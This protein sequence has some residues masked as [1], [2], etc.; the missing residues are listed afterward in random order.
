MK[1]TQKFLIV[2][3]A[4][5]SL[6]GGPTFAQGVASNTVAAD[7]NKQVAYLTPSLE[8]QRVRDSARG[9]YQS[10]QFEG[11]LTQYKSLC[12]STVANSQ[13]FYWLGESYFH[14]NRFNDAAQAFEQ[15][16]TIDPRAHDSWVRVVEA[17]LAGK[18]PQ[19]AKEKC[20]LA[21]QRVTDEYARKQ[22]TSL[23]RLCALPPG[24]DPPHVPCRGLKAV[25]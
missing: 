14:L 7:A 1:T 12:Q 16:V 21:L 17:Y 15:S 20:D 8:V 4:A 23:Q 5:T 13:D 2:A 22:L 18:Q 10:L 19:K 6:T 24:Q 3:V 9:T 11:A 25:E